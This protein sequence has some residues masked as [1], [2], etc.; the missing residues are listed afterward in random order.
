M[1]FNLH[2]SVSK[3]QFLALEIYFPLKIK[4]QAIGI[5]NKVF[6]LEIDKINAKIC[7]R[8]KKSLNVSSY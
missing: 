3:F 7:G 8:N 5:F 2:P 4:S 6:L 1:A